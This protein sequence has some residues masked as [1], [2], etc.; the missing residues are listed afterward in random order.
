MIK[1]LRQVKYP[2]R[3]AIRYAV[4]SSLLGLYHGI[5]LTMETIDTVSLHGKCVGSQ[6]SEWLLF[7]R[8]DGPQIQGLQFSLRCESLEDCLW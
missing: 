8:H 4:Y 2:F 5:H 3:I 7:H 6:V 1:L